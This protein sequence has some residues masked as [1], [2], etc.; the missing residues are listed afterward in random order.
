MKTIGRLALILTAVITGL[1]FLFTF[2][3]PDGRL[4]NPH[5]FLTLWKPLLQGLVIS[6]ATL[7]I[8]QWT[9]KGPLVR[10]TEWIKK[11]RLSGDKEPSTPLPSNLFEP[12]ANEVKYLAR[13]LSTARAAA[14]EEARLRQ[15]GESLWTP[16]RL[17][18]HVR[19]KLQDKSLFL[20]SN[21]EPY[22]HVWNGKQIDFNMPASGLV[23]A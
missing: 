16:E 3:F 1:V 5:W 2:S 22:R 11:M 17:K 20:I 10:V 21:R 9:I 19:A 8:V 12:L 23:T 14:E 4:H 15:T 6:A 18:E 7:L 13:S